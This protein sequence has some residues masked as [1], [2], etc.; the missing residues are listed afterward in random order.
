MRRKKL[1]MFQIRFKMLD[2]M[3]LAGMSLLVVVALLIFNAYTNNAE[4]N[5]ID[6]PGNDN[7][8]LGCGLWPEY[9]RDRCC[10]GFFD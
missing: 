3:L 1:G 9:H 2:R 6:F 7:A 5:Q 4:K 8:Y 10:Q